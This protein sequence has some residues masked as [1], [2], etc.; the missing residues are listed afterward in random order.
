MLAKA[1]LNTDAGLIYFVYFDGEKGLASGRYFVNLATKSGY[2]LRSYQTL[3][4]QSNSPPEFMS[5]DYKLDN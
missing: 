1:S 5:L 2:Q 3:D 4:V